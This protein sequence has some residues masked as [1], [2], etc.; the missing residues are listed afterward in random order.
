MIVIRRGRI[1]LSEDA[2]E[3]IR[4]A[5]GEHHPV[6]IGGVLVGVSVEGRPWVTHAAAVPSEH[7]TRIFYELP[8]GARHG[9]V[10]E[11][12]DDDCRLGYIGDWHAHPVDSGPSDTDLTTM[13]E[14]FADRDAACPRPVLLIARRAGGS[15]RVNA[16]QFTGRRLRNLR[17]IAAGALPPPE[18]KS[19]DRHDRRGRAGE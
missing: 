12:R 18:E 6:E 11:A 7:Q 4:A 8:E 17:V 15:Y 5:A 9:A 13:R 3:T 1:W 19:D 16:W 14:L 10:D 2:A